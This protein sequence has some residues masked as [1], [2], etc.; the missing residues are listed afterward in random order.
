MMPDKQRGK[1]WMMKAE[2]IAT[3]ETILIYCHH[4]EVRQQAHDRLRSLTGNIEPPFETPFK[5]NK[6]IYP[7]KKYES[8]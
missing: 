2:L 3:L 7:T 5:A 6:F 4:P 8:G 1:F